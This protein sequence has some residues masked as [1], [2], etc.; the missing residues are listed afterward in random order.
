MIIN[1]ENQTLFYRS[2]KG[3]IKRFTVGQWLA[4][5]RY[6]EERGWIRL[7]IKSPP[8]DFL[9]ISYRY[10]D[11]TIKV[12]GLTLEFDNNCHSMKKNKIEMLKKFVDYS[13]VLPLD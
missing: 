6:L 4:L 5:L 10:G 12:Q 7:T 1:F 9:Y 13:I 2:K 3:M 11:L 8:D